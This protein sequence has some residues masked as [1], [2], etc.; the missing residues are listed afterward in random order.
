MNRYNR[1]NR[2]ALAATIAQ[3]GALIG[4]L[5]AFGC[6][7][8]G[9]GLT[10]IPQNFPTQHNISDGVQLRI[11]EHGLLSLGE[12]VDT[13]L[14]SLMPNGLRFEIPENCESDPEICCGAPPGTCGIDIDVTRRPGETPRM[15]FQ[16]QAGPGSPLESTLRMRV[17][18]SPGP[19]LVKLGGSNCQLHLD[20]EE[21]DA[22]ALTVRSLLSFSPDPLT[23]NTRASIGTIEVD[24]LDRGDI[25]IDGGGFACGLADTFKGIAI[26]I[27]KEQIAEHAAGIVESQ[28][29][30]RCTSN[31]QCVP[32]GTCS[33]EGVCMINDANG[34]RCVQE[35]GM[36]GRM[37]ASTLHPA[38]SDEAMIDLR[39]VAGGQS[40]NANGGLSLG[41][42]SGIASGVAGDLADA[43]T[44]GPSSPPPAMPSQSVPTMSQLNRIDGVGDFDVAF[45]VHRAFLDRAGWAAYQSGLLCMTVDTSMVS[46][47]NSDALAAL[48]PSLGDLLPDGTGQLAVRLRP[49]APPTFSLSGDSL[50]E[51]HMSA[52][53]IDIFAMVDESFARLFTAHTALEIPVDVETGP[54]GGLIPVVGDIGQSFTKIEIT[55]S[56]MLEESPS[57][58]ASK[59]PAMGSLVSQ[60]LGEALGSIELPNLAGLSLQVPPGGARVLDDNQFLSVFAQ[61]VSST[62]AFK[63]GPV[64]TAA[65]IRDIRLPPAEAW[66]RTALRADEQPVVELA[67]AGNHAGDKAGDSQNGKHNL[68]WQVRVNGGLWSRFSSSSTLH[69]SRPEFWLPGQHRIEVRARRIG[70]PATI[71]PTPFVLTAEIASPHDQ[72]SK[73]AVGGSGD[74]ASRAAGKSGGCNAGSADASTLWSLALC[75]PLFVLVLRRRARKASILAGAALLS[76]TLTGCVA[77]VGDGV[78]EQETVNGRWSDIAVSE[79]R[80][81]V[82]A[83]EQ[84]YGD[85]VVS[86]VS[87]SGKVS[88]RPIDGV[89]AGPAPANADGEASGYR[90]GIT[91]PGD[92]V[93]SFTSVALVNGQGRIAYHDRSAGRLKLATEQGDAWFCHVVDEVPGATVG[94]Y[95]SL[96]SSVQGISGIAYM[97]HGVTKQDGTMVAQLRWAQATTTD[98]VSAADWTI[99]IIAE[100]AIAEI[101]S[102]VA[103]LPGGTGLY[104]SADFLPDGRAAVAFYDR[105]GGNLMLAIRNAQG[106][107]VSAL[108]AEDGTDTGPW[109]SMAIDASGTIHIVYQEASK[110]QLRYLVHRD[111][112]QGTGGTLVQTIDDGVRDG[113][114]HPVGAHATIV[115]DAVGRPSVFYQDQFAV[116]VMHAYRDDAGRWLRRPL[117]D[118]GGKS[119]R[120]GFAIAAA[121]KQ[122][123]TWV[124]SFDYDRRFFPPG[125]LTVTSVTQ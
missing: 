80:T 76:A 77:L 55:S 91:A 61:L 43:V 14:A 17:R 84:R 21:D 123:S 83:Y 120:G 50:L 79:D 114:K 42:A 100:S 22:P 12:N 102:A 3:I 110:G 23:G 122:A 101:E 56:G 10:A 86:E 7:Q 81:L 124:S 51:V 99:E 9:S 87:S 4:A 41:L 1:H 11:T 65:H 69:L 111:G 116:A 52:L 33:A 48:F 103:D 121:Q 63:Q 16:S 26:D 18:T 115:L 71:D 45:G 92:D 94:R 105:F 49:Q 70:Q 31:A 119:M 112:S 75:F 5:G 104:P 113:Q 57:E 107:S 53:D 72:R 2:Y 29:C 37:A 36:G 88:F 78:G 108:D 15:Q 90:D 20:T 13:V 27:M 118:M 34:S 58:I 64:E 117:S 98:P 6:A 25:D 40:G 67:L 54:S 47:L 46:V 24:D 73:I 68:E 44:C 85:L 8:D 89:P 95:I 28:L 66:A 109:A 39:L 60:L 35:L 97:A 125:R 59:F 38:L 93:G 82:A 19:L 106:W 32:H 74:E 62:A 96:A 30:R